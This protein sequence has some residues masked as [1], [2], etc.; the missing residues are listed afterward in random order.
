M[1][2]DSLK[3]VLRA[4]EPAVKICGVTDSD[5]AQKITQLGANFL[6][7]NF[8]PESKRYLGEPVDHPWVKELPTLRVGIFVNA[9]L[10][11]ILRLRD[12]GWIDVAQLHGDET[13]EDVANLK[14]AGLPVIKAI[15]LETRE[16][17]DDLAGFGADAILLDAPAA[18][19]RGGD[20]PDH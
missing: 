8:Y 20:W 6:G 7:L 15:G 14:A 2:K 13:P 9:S 1:T 12:D 10:S 5:E 3:N 16:T 11:E 4:K 17:I 19:E 18:E